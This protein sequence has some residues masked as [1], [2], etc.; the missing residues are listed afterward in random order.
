VSFSVDPK[1]RRGMSDSVK[2]VRRRRGRE[3]RIP[4]LRLGFAATTASRKG[5]KRALWLGEGRGKKKG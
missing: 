5:R 4:K 3:R 1:G 2:F